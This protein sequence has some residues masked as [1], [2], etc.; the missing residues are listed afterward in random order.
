MVSIAE[1]YRQACNLGVSF[2]VEGD[3]IKLNGA[4]SLTSQLRASM[5]SNKP[6]LIEYLNSARR[7]LDD[8]G[9][10]VDYVTTSDRAAD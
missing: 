10:I 7:L 1:E 3:A 8:K 2:I 6:A 9:V 5:R 4:S